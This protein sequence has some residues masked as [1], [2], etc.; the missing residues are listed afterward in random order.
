MVPLDI[1]IGS[2]M[3]SHSIGLCFN[4]NRA[5]PLPAGSYRSFGRFID[6]QNIVAVQYDIGNAKGFRYFRD[7]IVWAALCYRHM[8]GIEIVF[9]DEDYW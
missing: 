3:T 2:D 6:S 5:R 7:I 9:T 8:G 4:E 1:V